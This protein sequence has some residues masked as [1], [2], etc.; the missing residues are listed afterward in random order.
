MLNT[1]CDPKKPWI[2]PLSGR[3]ARAFV[4]NR[5]VNSLADAQRVC[6]HL[7]D[8]GDEPSSVIGIPIRLVRSGDEVT[9]ALKGDDDLFLTVRIAAITKVEPVNDLLVRVGDCIEVSHIGLRSGRI[10]RTGW[11]TLTLVN[12]HDPYEYW[13]SCYKSVP[14]A[15]ETFNLYDYF[16]ALLGKSDTLRTS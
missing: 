8:Q 7:V 1:N 10:F 12:L 6:V 16:P 9:V 14:L 11:N 5:L 2:Q 4:L 13:T 15:G 3:L